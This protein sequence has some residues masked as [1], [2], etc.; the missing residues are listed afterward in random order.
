MIMTRSPRPPPRPR[1]PRP[2]PARLVAN[3]WGHKHL[4]AGRRPSPS[5]A[6]PSP[7]AFALGLALHLASGR[8]GEAGVC[9]AARAPLLSFSPGAGG[10]SR[11]RARPG[12]R[13]APALGDTAAGPSR[14]G[15]GDSARGPQ[16]RE[17]SEKTRR[18][19]APPAARHRRT[20]CGERGPLTLQNHLFDPK[21]ALAHRHRPPPSPIPALF[22]SQMT[23]CPP[24]R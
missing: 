1:P 18:L 2:V 21:G 4:Q 23:L 11:L 3:R 9:E 17:D 8:R 5:Q 6:A 20:R 13:E 22:A 16:S 12:E 15:G 10:Q 24:Q 19:G 14:H 7:S